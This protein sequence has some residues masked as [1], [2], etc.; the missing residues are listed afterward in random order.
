MATLLHLSFRVENPERAAALYADLLDGRV[1]E[2]IGPP[3]G[4]IG[5]QIV[6]FGRNAT[7]AL[8]DQIELWPAAKHWSPRGFVDVEPR[9][10]PF[11]HFAVQSDKPHE[12]LAAIADKHGATVAREE[13]GMSDLVTVVYDHDGNFVEF[14]PSST[15][16]A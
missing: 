3:L 15:R 4:T 11:G 8:L 14:F 5:V 7:N 16:A 10:M 6:T 2:K 9:V 1:I 12:E 13:R